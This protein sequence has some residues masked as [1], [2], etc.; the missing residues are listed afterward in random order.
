LGVRFIGRYAF[1]PTLDWP[2]QRQRLAV[3]GGGRLPDGVSVQTTSYG[4]VPVEQV[5]SVASDPTRLVVHLHGGGYC[6]GSPG[7]AR[8]WAARL[9]LEAGVTVLLPDYRLAPEHPYPAALEDA[10]AVWA[11]IAAESLPAAPV[12]SGD[13]AGGG[14]AVALACRLRDQIGASTG[15]G[16]PSGLVLLS[17]WLDLTAD[18]QADRAL[19]RRD[20][21]LR[22][23][24][25]AACAVAYAAPHPLSHPEISPL[26]ARLDGLPPTLVQA[27]ADDV[28]VTDARRFG[29][30]A[31]EAGVAVH[32]TIVPGLWHDFPLQAGMV[33]EGDSA[34]RQAATFITRLLPAKPAQTAVAD[35]TVVADSTVVTG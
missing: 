3:A 9:A 30:A 33:A 21:M 22:P 34:V 32:A 7:I 1:D 16:L 24:W 31:A 25:L 8:S 11:G 29:T 15:P 27:G 26:F 28:L 4:G 5:T 23:D 10:Q 14:L 35:A 18:R 19:A 12:L 20:P 13:S 17:P 2:V 6:V